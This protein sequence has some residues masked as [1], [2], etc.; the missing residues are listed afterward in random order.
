MSSFGQGRALIIGIA[1]YQMVPSLPDA[2]RNDANG[3]RQMLVSPRCGY[4][5]E[6]VTSLIDAQA[7]RQAIL[8][9]L[10][11]LAR[12]VT[13]KDTV[14]VYFSGHGGRTPGSSNAYVIVH[15]TDI[16]D[17]ANTAISAALL[18]DKLAAIGAKKLVVFLDCCHAAGT[19]VLK[20]ASAWKAPFTPGLDS[21][22]LAPLVEEEGRVIA[23]LWPELKEQRPLQRDSIE[24]IAS[25]WGRSPRDEDGD[26]L[27]QAAGSEENS[28]LVP[29]PSGEHEVVIV[30]TSRSVAARW[31]D[32]PAVSGQPRGWANRTPTLERWE[33]CRHAV[34]ATSGALSETHITKLRTAEREVARWIVDE[35]LGAKISDL[36]KRASEADDPSLE[37]AIVD[38]TSVTLILSTDDASH[39]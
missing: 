32:E 19:A 30:A 28:T 26:W 36:L 15:D 16:A 7:M 27:P 38:E 21:K 4:L 9:V 24:Q 37:V 3:L 20:E 11:D 17:L 33:S 25:A 35:I 31:G 13:D 22:E 6:R 18:T 14:F 5:P 34:L 10:D 2:I 23:K 12:E 1:G 39:V 8:D 29:E